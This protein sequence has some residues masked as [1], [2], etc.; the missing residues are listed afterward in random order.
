MT[1]A[2]VY[3]TARVYGLARVYGT[4]RWRALPAEGS[5][6]LICS[7]W[8]VSWACQELQGVGCHVEGRR[9]CQELGGVQGKGTKL[10]GHKVQ[11]RALPRRDDQA[12]KANS[13]LR[14]RRL[15]ARRGRDALWPTVRLGALLVLRELQRCLLRLMKRLLQ[16]QRGVTVARLCLAPPPRRLLPFRLC[17]C[18]GFSTPGFGLPAQGRKKSTSSLRRPSHLSPCRCAVNRQVSG[19]CHRTQRFSKLLAAGVHVC[20]L[21][22]AMSSGCCGRSW[23]SCGCQLVAPSYCRT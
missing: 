3:G 4:A 12:A 14:R 21:A 9:C 10:L 6:C 11:R 23:Y 15:H 5:L 1:R 8:E 13:A 19:S 16:P 22:Q 7:G 2:R 20:I 17:L 18:C